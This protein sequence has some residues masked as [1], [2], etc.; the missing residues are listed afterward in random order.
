[1]YLYSHTPAPTQVQYI[2]IALS[3]YTPTHWPF[4]YVYGVLHAPDWR[5]RFANDLAKELPRIPFAADFRAF[6]RAGRDLAALH[7]G[8]ETGPEY[9]LE[10]EFSGLGPPQPAHFRLGPSRMR[11]ADPA[12]TALRI[13][14]HITLRNIPAEAH[15]YTVNGRTPLEWLIDRYRITRDP[16][17]ALV[18][19][20]NA[21]FATPQALIP[22]IRRAVRVA[23][24]TA[25]I[26]ATLPP[27]RATDT[28][29]SR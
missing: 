11:F 3:T 27:W 14:E 29:R 6:A 7:L 5:R 1:M 4:D 20:P 25:K 15:R 12:R 2:H 19:D 22:T 9:P 18:N 17:S 13:N 28:A 24:D 8:Y 23:V 26:V 16:Q 21:W 10:L